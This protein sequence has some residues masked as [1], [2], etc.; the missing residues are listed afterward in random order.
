MDINHFDDTGT[1]TIAGV[2]WDMMGSEKSMIFDDVEKYIKDQH[3][4]SHLKFRL[5]TVKELVTI[6]D[7]ISANPIN[8]FDKKTY[9]ANEEKDLVLNF[10]TGICGYL[11]IGQKAHVI[12]VRTIT[13][14]E[15]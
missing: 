15:K 9:F 1:V 14:E 11:K 4:W 6:F 3:Y 2:M 5:P 10:D 8:D 13:E 7:Y 12:C